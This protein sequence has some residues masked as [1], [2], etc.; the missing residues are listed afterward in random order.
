MDIDDIIRI[1][2]ETGADAIHPGY[3]FLSENDEFA[4]AVEAAGIKFVGP[5]V[6]HLKMFGDKITAKQ[7][8]IKAGVPTVPGTDHPV[9]S[10]EEA[11]AF[12]AEH[13]YPLFVKS[14]AGGGGRGM[15]V[16]E[17]DDELREAFERAASEAQQSFGKAEIYLEKYLQDP[18]HVEIQ[19]LADEQGEVMHLF[20][21]D[22]SIQ[23]RHQKIIEFAPAVSVSVDMRRRI[24]DAAV[25]LMQSVDY[26]S[27]GTVEFFG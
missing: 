17:H 10:I 5:R 3:G 23:R 7:A 12:G 25:K 2:K 8:A 11:L 1:A 6:E 15:R 21:R 4:S 9:E 27:A 20:E 13:G 26:Q 22:S 14:A 24:Q 19:I 16:V 18:K